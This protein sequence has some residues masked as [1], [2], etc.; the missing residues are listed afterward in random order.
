MWRLYHFLWVKFCG[1]STKNLALDTKKQT[2]PE[3]AFVLCQ[4]QCVSGKVE[5]LTS[6]VQIDFFAPPWMGFHRLRQEEVAAMS[7]NH[8]SSH[9]KKE[10]MVC[11]SLPLHS[12]IEERTAALK[13]G[14]SSTSSHQFS[15]P[16][17]AFR[18]FSSPLDPSSIFKIIQT[19][20]VS[21]CK[22][23][24][25]PLCPHQDPTLLFISPQ[26]GRV[27]LW[28]LDHVWHRQPYNI[29]HSWTVFFTN[30]RLASWT[31]M[32]RLMVTPR[33]VRSLWLRNE[34]KESGGGTQKEVG[35]RHFMSS[36]KH[37]LDHGCLSGN[38]MVY[39]LHPH[40]YHSHAHVSMM[41]THTQDCISK[42]EMQRPTRMQ[43]FY[44]M[45]HL[46]HTCRRQRKIDEQN[47]IENTSQTVCIAETIS[48]QTAGRELRVK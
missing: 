14:S 4:H 44:N 46:H 26:P 41:A 34:G 22:A 36:L 40:I 12:F 17:V 48:K 30:R 3:A 35:C 18:A 45:E 23:V 29:H 7:C 31:I 32:Q 42:E 2:H 5:R 25:P 8:A 20:Y 6:L 27:C 13:T 1:F 16:S 38:W 15:L 19:T 47:L 37:G 9:Q 28:C 39:S 11:I 33:L 21:V 43:C 24:L 10:M